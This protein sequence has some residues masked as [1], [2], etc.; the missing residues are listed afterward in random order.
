MDL[1]TPRV[2]Q[3]GPNR[4]E[5]SHGDDQQLYVQFSTEAI[6]QAAE[7]EKEGRPIFKDV[8]YITIMFPG[9]R[10]REIKRPVRFDPEE[11]RPYPPDPERFHRQWAAFQSK[12]EQAHDGTPLEQWPPL[13]NAAVMELKANRIFTVEQLSNIPDSAL[14]TLGMGGREMRD[15]ASSWLKN[16]KD[17]SEITR[18]VA[19]NSLLKADIEALKTQFAELAATQ[20]QTT[21]TLNAKA[22]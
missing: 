15:K 1:A 17:G 18:L 5:V 11:S 6:H 3:T 9:D 16:A 4:Y 2:Q 22:K 20:K 12:Q 19:E 7:S 13:S 8:P 10:S 21:L 14:H